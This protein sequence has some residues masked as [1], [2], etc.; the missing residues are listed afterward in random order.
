MREDRTHEI[1]FGGFELHRNNEALNQLGHLC[2][3]HVRA[4]ELAPPDHVEEIRKDL[5]VTTLRYQT[6]E[7][8]VEAVGMPEEKLCLYCWTGQCPKAACPKTGID[9][10]AAQKRSRKKTAEDTAQIKLW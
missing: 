1:F 4:D 2:A 7:D 6:V 3:N 9:I 10:V 5:G 8:M